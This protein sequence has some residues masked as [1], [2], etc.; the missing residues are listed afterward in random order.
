MIQNLLLLLKPQKAVWLLF[1][2]KGGTLIFYDIKLPD[3][4]FLE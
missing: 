1:F 3:N 2:D 4:I